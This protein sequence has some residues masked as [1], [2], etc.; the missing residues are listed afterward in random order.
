MSSLTAWL[1]GCLSS[2]ARSFLLLVLI[3]WLLLSLKRRLGNLFFSMNPNKVPDPDGFSVGFFH[4]A[5]RIVGE[6]V[7]EAVLEFFETGPLPWFPKG[8]ILPPWVTIG[9]Y[10]AVM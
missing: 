10:P 1:V 7:T 5:W 8:K 4:K 9:P 2:Y 6:D 3:G